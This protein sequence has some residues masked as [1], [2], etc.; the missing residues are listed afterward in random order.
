M[1]TKALGTV[2]EWSGRSS[3]PADFYSGMLDYWDH[4]QS[5]DPRLAEHHAV[6]ST[7]AEAF[8]H[9]LVNLATYAHE[10]L[11]WLEPSRIRRSPSVVVV[12]GMTEA[13]IFTLRSACDV[14]A[15]ALA[16]YA[17]EKRGQAPK[18]SLRGLITWSE[19]NPS[20]VHAS[21]RTVLAADFGW[22]WKLRALRD[23]LGH[24]GSHANI[25]C[26][27]RQFNLW[28]HGPDGWITREPLL[29]LL[30]GQLVHLVDLSD[31]SAQAINEVIDFPPDRLKSRIVNGVLI[32]ALHDLLKTADNY[33]E[34]SP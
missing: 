29:P 23:A 22:F 8:G 24:R 25:H 12:G 27:G 18:D 5:I 28:L 13:F 14:I 17:A 33:A 20:R 21:I 30:A 11:S 15:T 6:L 2:I 31:S 7:A 9:D 4:W 16:H 19:R 1:Q 10:I 3:T 34:P 32:S 26:D